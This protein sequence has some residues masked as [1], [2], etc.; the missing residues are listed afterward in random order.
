MKLLYELYKLI[1]K[2]KLALTRH[3]KFG[4]DVNLS[5]STQIEGYNYFGSNVDIGGSTIGRGTY[6]ASNSKVVLTKVGRFC[7]IGEGVRTCFGRHPVTKYVSSHPAFF[8]TKGQ[9]GFTFVKDDL[10]EEH[11]YVDEQK[12][13]V[14]NIGHDVW[15]GNDVK[16]L[17]GISVGNG[18]IIGLGSIVTKDILPYSI[19]VGVPSRQIGFR[20]SETEIAAL[21][22]VKWWNKDY[23]YIASNAHLFLDIEDF[24]GSFKGNLI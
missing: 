9:S 18:A 14:V 7:S 21:E 6:I 19:N 15:I 8:S 3:V 10:F 2:R 16:I 13:Y 5:R 17:D 11:Q 24:F 4:S 20:F 1:I 23:D 22:A 12:K